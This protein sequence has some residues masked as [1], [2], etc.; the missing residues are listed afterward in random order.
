M[1]QHRRMRSIAIN[2]INDIKA[3]ENDD[4]F[5]T[6][7]NKIK[8]EIT[9]EISKTG[10]TS[11][12]Q[13]K[14]IQELEGNFEKIKAAGMNCIKALCKMAVLKQKCDGLLPPSVMKFSDSDQTDLK[15]QS[16]GLKISEASPWEPPKGKDEQVHY[17]KQVKRDERIQELK[18]REEQEQFPLGATKDKDQEKQLLI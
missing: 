10:R 5:Q 15:N 16:D 9:Q 6:E 12:I 13:G 1:S 18:K 2:L 3:V 17:Q 7:L 11:E 14:M 8:Q 4:L